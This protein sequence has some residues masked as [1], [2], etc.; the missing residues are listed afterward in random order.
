MQIALVLWDGN[1]G[2]AEKVTAELAGGLRAIGVD[3][4]VVFVRD[5]ATLAADLDRLE[6]PYTSLGA[7]R[8]EEVLWRPRRFARLV[9]VHGPDGVLLPAVGHQAPALRIGGYRAPIVAIEHGFLLLMQS[10]APHWRLARRLERLMSARFVDVEVAV[11]DFMRE[12][13]MDGPHARRVERIHNGIDIARYSAAHDEGTESG[14]VI[15]C[16]SRLVAGKG[17]DALLRAFRAVTAEASGAHLRIAGAGPEREHIA[18]LIRREGLSD[19]VELVG[20]VDDLP[21]FWSDVDVAAMPSNLPES[22]GMVALEAMASAK[23]VVATRSG[24]VAE[25]VE[26]G[27]NGRLVPVGDEAAM[28]RALLGYVRDAELRRAHGAAG[29]A[30]CE[31]DFEIERCAAH[32]ARL[33][34][35]L[36][37]T[38]MPAPRPVDPILE[39]VNA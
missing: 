33:F 32:Y 9:E 11:S 39:E 22:F 19:S 13:V 14:C 25:L 30:R 3:A 2:G 23:P 34:A 5:P 12:S 6:V 17:I 26:D 29:R 4:S 7:R 8:V 38:R 37:S 24:G 21:A 10:M 36:G 27:V 18:E 20:A 35:D 15:G 16:A 1:V 31:S 28:T